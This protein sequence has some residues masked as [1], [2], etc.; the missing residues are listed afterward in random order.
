MTTARILLVDDV[1]VFL[2]FERSFF[3]RAGCAILTASTGEEALR[4]A[5]EERPHVVLLDYEMP[6]MNGDEV[7]RR[8]RENPATRHIPVMIVTTHAR[9]EVV[10]A[11]R[12][13]GCTDLLFKPVKGADLLHK[14][15][16]LLQIPYRVAVRCRVSVEVG[17]GM[18]GEAVALVGYSED[19]SEGGMRVELPEPLEVAAGVKLRFRLP[20]EDAAI[21]ATGEI[22][23]VDSRRERGAFSAGIRFVEPGAAARESIRRFVERSLTT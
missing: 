15:L 1:R 13:A 22:I 21:E 23:R 18:S 2:E 4:I 17:I 20:E 8:L 10:E 5:Q 7:C 12:R 19:V 16:H 14:V 9:P 6:G 3:D 11:C